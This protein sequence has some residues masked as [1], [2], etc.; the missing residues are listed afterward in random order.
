MEV[1]SARGATGLLES[2]TEYLYRPDGQR[3]WRHFSTYDTM[4]RDGL[5]P[6]GV[7]P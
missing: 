3:D 6:I 1:T 4:T 2:R 5:F 7:E